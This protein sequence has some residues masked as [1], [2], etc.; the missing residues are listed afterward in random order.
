MI[1]TSKIANEDS[2]LKV[3]SKG[4][5]ARTLVVVFGKEVRKYQVFTPGKQ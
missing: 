5:L 4:L 3:E 1:A 2:S